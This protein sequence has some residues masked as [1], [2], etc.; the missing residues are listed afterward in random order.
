MGEVKV[1]KM[2]T[3]WR[4]YPNG[5]VYH[6]RTYQVGKPQAAGKQKKKVVKPLDTSGEITQEVSL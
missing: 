2:M 5:E 6:H 1:I 4:V 3:E